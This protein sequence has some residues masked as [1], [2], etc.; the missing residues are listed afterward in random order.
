MHVYLRNTFI[1]YMH[2]DLRLF[3]NKNV[4]KQVIMNVIVES[5][6]KALKNGDNIFK[7]LFQICDRKKDQ[8]NDSE[9]KRKKKEKKCSTGREAN[10]S[11]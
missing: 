5:S 10:L 4:F 8:D 7:M 6:K 1:P 11:G 9:K 2:V 3:L